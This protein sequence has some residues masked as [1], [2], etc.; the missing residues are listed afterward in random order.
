[1]ATVVNGD[2]LPVST[3]QD[4][5]IRQ[6]HHIVQPPDLVYW[7]FDGLP[8]LLVDNP[9]HLG[10]QLAL[11]LIQWPTGQ[12]SATPFISATRPSASVAITASPMLAIVV[13]RNSFS[14]TN[15]WRAAASAVM[16]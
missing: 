2:V 12:C 4:R 5:V 7:I 11:R 6:S 1:S 16:S 14:R 3:D 10:E 15:S 8:C 9:K 13:A